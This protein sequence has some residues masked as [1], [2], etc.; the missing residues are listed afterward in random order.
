VPG[1]GSAELLSELGPSRSCYSF[2]E[3]SS[4]ADRYQH[5]LKLLIAHGRASAGCLYLRDEL[6]LKLVAAVGGEPPMR[7]LEDELLQR[8][9]RTQSLLNSLDALDEETKIFDSIPA[10]PRK[11]NAAGAPS[12]PANAQQS[13]Q[14]PA[15]SQPAKPLQRVVVLTARSGGFSKPIGGVILTLL[16][17][18]SGE[19]DPQLLHAVA[20]A[21]V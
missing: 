4:P 20:E 14:P 6:G 1:V 7:E 9:E 3:L 5:A 17:D 8:I 19:L 2:A 11:R 16:P 13:A 15:A 18:A 10:A 12:T 21:L